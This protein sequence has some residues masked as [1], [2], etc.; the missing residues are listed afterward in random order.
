MQAKLRSV[1]ARDRGL[2]ED[3]AVFRERG[4]EATFL[5]SVYAVIA[6]IVMY[7]AIMIASDNH[8]D[9]FD[10]V[11]T[12]GGCLVLAQN[13]DQDNEQT[14]IGRDHVAGGLS[15]RSR[16]YG[17][18]TVSTQPSESM[19]YSK[20]CTVLTGTMSTLGLANGRRS[21]STVISPE[22]PRTNTI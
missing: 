8:P 10:P 12:V 11:V 20:P 6:W 2:R 1:F 22:P 19:P 4:Y 18:A 17:S 21:V 3:L 7:A 9:Y 15:S 13:G 5:A 16:R 14:G